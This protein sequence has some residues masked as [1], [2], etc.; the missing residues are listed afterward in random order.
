M[1]WLS[2]CAAKYASTAARSIGTPLLG[3]GMGP[4]AASASGTPAGDLRED[5]EKSAGETLSGGSE[6]GSTFTFFLGGGDHMVNDSNRTA[7]DPGLADDGFR[8]DDRGQAGLDR[9]WREQEPVAPAEQE[10]VSKTWNVFYLFICTISS[11]ARR[12]AKYGQSICG[13]K[14]RLC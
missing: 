4:T 12:A 10:C 2:L 1:E 6:T 3:P 13:G 8:K 9:T 7:G 11:G 5:P 14:M